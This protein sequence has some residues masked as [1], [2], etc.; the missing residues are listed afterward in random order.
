MPSSFLIK[1]LFPSHSTQ[2]DAIVLRNLLRFRASVIIAVLIAIAVMHILHSPIENIQTVLSVLLVSFIVTAGQFFTHRHLTATSRLTLFLNITFDYFWVFLFVLLFGKSSNPFIYYYL[3][4][5]AIS[6]SIFNAKAAWFFCVASIVIYSGLLTS[7]ISLHF[8]HFTSDFQLHLMGMWLNF[9]GSTILTCFFVNK[10]STQLRLRQ[11]ALIEARENT[12]KKEQIVGLGT[13]AA[14]TMHALATPLSTITVLLE[15]L[16]EEG[17]FDQHKDD[18][19]LVLQQIHRCKET[20]RKLSSSITEDE[21]KYEPVQL[22]QERIAEYCSLHHPEANL[23]VKSDAAASKLT[24]AHSIL[25]DHAIINLINNAIEGTTHRVS[26]HYLAK[27]GALLIRVCNDVPKTHMKKLENWGQ[28][29]LSEKEMGMGIGAFLAN[30]TIEKLGGSVTISTNAQSVESS[31]E[32]QRRV[33]DLIND[34]SH[35]EDLNEWIETC[36]EIQLPVTGV[37]VVAEPSAETTKSEAP[38]DR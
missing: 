22:L 12:L 1:N 18:S 15:D 31:N 7:D 21:G 24:L 3:A 10:L 8:H 23:E 20:M 30:S 19:E 6:A 14:T 34:K 16:V 5:V 2:H 37:P 13:V 9:V 27:D 32:S 26:I 35:C 25:L 33:R 36:V 17:V 11:Q 38:Y 4:L 29:Q 28:P